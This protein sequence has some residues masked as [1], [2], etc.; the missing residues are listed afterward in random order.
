M[1]LLC[2][3]VNKGK[4]LAR[5]IQG[6]K[7]SSV[8][9]EEEVTRSGISCVNDCGLKG[10]GRSIWK[11]GQVPRVLWKSQNLNDSGF[12]PEQSGKKIEICLR[13]ERI[14][15]C[16]QKAWPKWRVF[17]RPDWTNCEQAEAASELTLLWA[18][19]WTRH[20]L[21]SLPTLTIPQT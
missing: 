21:R 2:N 1:L 14:S 6:N 13:H 4:H 8:H 9:R 11:G 15:C 3:V 18:G 17:Q 12:S 19:V 20:L 10:L 5:D 16:L 7:Y